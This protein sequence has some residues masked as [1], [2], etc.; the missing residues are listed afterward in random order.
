M[1][2]L[3]SSYTNW[4]PLESIIVGR[5]YRPEHFDFIQNQK[6]KDQLSQLLQEAEEDLQNLCDTIKSYGAEVVRPDLPNNEF[7]Q[8]LWAIS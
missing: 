7:L 6:V 3:I 1:N 8:Q 2:N 5:V 4:Q